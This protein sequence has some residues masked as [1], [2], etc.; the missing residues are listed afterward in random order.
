MAE[1][2]IQIQDNGNIVSCGHFVMCPT[3]NEIRSC[4]STRCAW[5]NEEIVSM[6][7]PHSNVVLAKCDHRLIVRLKI[8][9][10]AK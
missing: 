3:G 4:C 10:G 1:R 7:P 9:G 5:Y 6:P 8:P 2:I